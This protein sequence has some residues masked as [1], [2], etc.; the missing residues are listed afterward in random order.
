MSHVNG[1]G[2]N[3]NGKSIW[4]AIA[5]LVTAA[6]AFGRS[7]IGISPTKKQPPESEERLVR[8]ETK[9]DLLWQ[10]LLH[11]KEQEDERDPKARLEDH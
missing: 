11:R 7:L 9:L 2:C 6:L 5:G 8:I 3:G 10:E 1:N 4:L